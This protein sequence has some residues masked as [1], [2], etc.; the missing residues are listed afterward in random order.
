MARIRVFRAEKCLEFIASYGNQRVFSIVDDAHFSPYGDVSQRLRAALRH[1][2]AISIS[3]VYYPIS[4]LN[5]LSANA[6]CP[7]SARCCDA[8]VVPSPRPGRHKSPKLVQVVRARA[9][10]TYR[11]VK[12]A[13]S[14]AQ[15]K[16]HTT[17]EGTNYKYII[18][19]S[20]A[21]RSA[22]DNY[23]ITRRRR[24]RN[25]QTRYRFC[26]WLLIFFP[27]TPNKK[28]YCNL[29]AFLFSN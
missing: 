1:P 22:S 27:R 11:R 7:R 24:L 18:A 14:R 8:R 9:L 17:N 25:S 5:L 13:L 28:N 23:P 16:T 10:G 20:G 15:N 4:L 29:H 12:L 3:Q 26:C 2:S 21:K 6:N 19:E